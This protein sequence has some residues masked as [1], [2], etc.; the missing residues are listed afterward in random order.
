MNLFDDN[1]DPEREGYKFHPASRK[2]A[3]YLLTALIVILLIIIIRALVTL[4]DKKFWFNKCE[5]TGNYKA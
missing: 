5:V 1:Y 3:T 2:T 4:S